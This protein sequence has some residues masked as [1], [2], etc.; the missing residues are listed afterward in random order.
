[1]TIQELVNYL[2]DAKRKYYAGQAEITDERFDQLEEKLRRLDPNNPYFLQVGAPVLGPGK[3]LHKVPMKSLKKV[4]NVEKLSDWL[5]KRM[6]SN[7]DV[8]IEGKIDGVSLSIKYENQRLASASTR[9]DGLIGRD[10]TKIAK[11]IQDIPQTIPIR[12]SVEIR[13]ETY[14][15]IST[16][17]RSDK[18][19]KSLRNMA[20]GIVNRKEGTEDARYLKFVAYDCLGL[21]F[22]NEEDKLEYISS[23]MPN[24]IQYDKANNVE[25]VASVWEEYNKTKRKNIDFEIDGLVIKI[26]DSAIQHKWIGK[27]PHHPDNITAW[28]FPIEQKQTILRQVIWTLGEKGKQTPVAIFDPVIIQG[29][30]I[31]K[32]TLHNIKRVQELQ[33]HIGDIISIGLG[34]D[35]IPIVVSNITMNISI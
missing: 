28:K 12:E 16:S 34:G 25:E 2:I 23:F 13:G 7:I 3:I 9:G 1:M 22:P 8:V 21:N 35:V 31:S 14:L 19:N 20:A 18:E 24:V 32:A 30:T 4:K 11:N 5:D 27:N 29:R 6:G 15:P 33:L 26:N 17:F 10:V